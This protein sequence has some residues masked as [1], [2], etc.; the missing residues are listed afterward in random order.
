MSWDR[1][2]GGTAS[3]GI[4]SIQLTPDGGYILAGWT[5]SY[6][7]GGSDAWLIRTDA[8]GIKQWDRTFGEVGNDEAT[9]V[10]ST[11]DG[12]YILAGGTRSYG[13]GSWDAWLIK[14]DAMGIK[15]WDRTFGGVLNDAATCVQPTLDG[16]YILAGKASPVSVYKSGEFDAWLI[17][18]RHGQVP[19]EEDAEK[20]I[21]WEFET[22]GDTEGWIP[23]GMLSGGS[24]NYRD[25]VVEDGVLKLKVVKRAACAYMLSP[26]LDFDT[27]LL[28]RIEV[29]ARIN[30]GAVEGWCTMSWRT[31]GY[32]ASGRE[33]ELSRYRVRLHRGQ[34]CTWSEEWRVFE[35]ANL[36]AHETWSGTLERIQLFFQFG[37]L[38]QPVEEE[39]LPDEVWVER[40]M[41]TG[42][43]LQAL[44]HPLE[45]PEGAKV[46]AWFDPA[47][48][49]GIGRTS[50][51][52]GGDLDGD[53]WPD[54]AVS[55]QDPVLD[56]Y[57]LVLLFNE[58]DGTF[59]RQERYPLSSWSLVWGGD[60][61]GDGEP[62]VVV[63]GGDNRSL[64][65]YVNEG[66]GQLRAGGSYR[67]GEG[68][69]DVAGA[70]LDG[71]GDVDLVVGNYGA[72]I[73][74]VEAHH[75]SVLFN[76][77][78]G[79]FGEPVD[80][81]DVGEHPGWVWAGDLD[82]DGD[83]DMVVVSEGSF[84]DW[85]K[86]KEDQT[87]E[88]LYTF[89]NDG[90]GGFGERQLYQVGSI[91]GFPWGGDLNGDGAVDLV[92][93]NNGDNCLSVLINAG[94]GHFQEAAHYDAGQG[95][96]GLCGGDF[97]G[98]GDL[99]LA[100]SR[101]VGMD[102]V[103]WANEG[104]ADLVF[105]GRYPLMEAAGFGLEALD[106]DRDG[107]LDIVGNA[108]RA[109]FVMMNRLRGGMTSLSEGQS[110]APVPRLCVLYPSVPNPFNAFTTILFDLSF[111]GRVRLGVYDVLGRKVRTLLD[112]ERD[113]GSWTV[114]WDGRDD[115]GHPVGSGW[116][117]YRLQVGT[118][119]ESKTM[120][121]IK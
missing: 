79:T 22:D 111:S 95:L 110:I 29:R 82:G 100:V 62:D 83:A 2:F 7:A 24:P 75:V 105:E 103:V 113:G 30:E 42:I 66:G 72:K 32:P 25:V 20:A 70:D 120:T 68:P 76:Q 54:L 8:M 6:G 13:A 23:F 119:S 31:P 56:V 58:G 92:V 43:G 35:A 12:G 45:M 118:F 98:D 91:P 96:R 38:D 49:Y 78:D 52:F 40:I 69:S 88:Y 55:T 90:T 115:K 106:V 89:F 81:Y 14:T 59:E 77:G 10:E 4:S 33:P 67:V 101:W 99:D 84:D 97:D 85:T 37:S 5:A 112:G 117:V 64:L 41:L 17:Y 9:W 65:V 36:N 26:R 28:D 94:D 18:Y 93:V 19:G 121:L 80:Y 11:P 44:E 48:E 73:E 63:T 86:G 116:Y 60:L 50:W 61:D 74:D 39:H 21:T 114:R 108:K 51:F 107:D 1:T 34:T 104:D 71:D 47:I 57:N 16:G 102:V 109:I 46:G 87:P 15:Q 27:D 3:E 53:G